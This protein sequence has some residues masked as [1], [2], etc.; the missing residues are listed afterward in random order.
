MLGPFVCSLLLRY[1]DYV[2]ILRL[3]AAIPVVGL[4]AFLLVNR[5]GS[6]LSWNSRKGGESSPFGSLGEI[7]A[8]RNVLALSF[9][10][11]AFSFADGIFFTMF[12][13]YA[14]ENLLMASSTI[15]FLI[16]IKGVTNMVFRFPSGRLSDKVGYRT[17]LVLSYSMLAVTY[18]MI[19]ESADFIMLSIAMAVYGLGHAMRAVTEWTLMGESMTPNTS[20]VAAAF[21][22]TMFNV[23]GA[24]GAMTSG[25]LA[26]ALPI[27]SIFK[28]ASIVVLPGAFIPFL[29]KRNRV[30]NKG[31]SA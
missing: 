27:H 7:L 8:S 17:P 20:T 14:S 28:I 25:L 19:S 15:A 10:R 2:Q 26:L 4:A 9:L 16:G 24:M 22:S 12:A 5:K 30:K 3:V 21:L 23:G 1:L 18:L 11:L 29:T 31:D 13:V 6:Y